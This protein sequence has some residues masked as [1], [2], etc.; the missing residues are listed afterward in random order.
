MREFNTREFNTT[1][2]NFGRLRR[3]TTLLDSVAA[4]QSR[5]EFDGLEGKYLPFQEMKT[6]D[7]AN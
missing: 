1:V 3:P 4:Q 5:Y 7:F 6:T 2:W